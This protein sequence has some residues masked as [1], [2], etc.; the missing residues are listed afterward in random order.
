[1]TAGIGSKRAEADGGPMKKPG[2]LG[3]GKREG[4]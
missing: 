3:E 4:K 1:M 2:G